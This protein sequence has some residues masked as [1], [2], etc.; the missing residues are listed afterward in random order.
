MSLMMPQ[1]WYEVLFSGTSIALLGAALAAL[2][3]GIGSAKG[4]GIAGE[5]A[6]GLISEIRIGSGR[7]CCC[8]RCRERRG[9]MVY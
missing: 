3:A 1:A 4:V 2:L 6:S 9:F 8:R 7:L 5:A